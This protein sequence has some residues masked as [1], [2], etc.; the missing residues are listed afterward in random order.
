MIGI[1]Q[2]RVSPPVNGA[3]Q[4]F[5]KDTWR[6]EFKI[7]SEIGYDA[8]ELVFDDCENPLLDFEKAQE[9]KKLAD[10]SGIT[11]SSVSVDYTMHYPLFGETMMKS[12]RVVQ[13]LIRR[14]YDIGIHRIGIAFEDNSSITA[15]SQ[16]NQSIY[17]VQ[18]CVKI[19]EALN[20]IVT[21]ET[22]L[23][24]ANV[25]EFIRRIDSP[26]LKINFDLGNSCA[27]GEYP[28]DVIRSLG[29]LIGGIHIKDR[30]ML[31]GNTVP[32]GQ[33]DVDFKACFDAL[34]D[35]GYSGSLIIQG[36]RGSDDV[37]TAKVYLGF[38]RSYLR[39]RWV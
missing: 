39:Q 4:A 25:K 13:E 11:I 35:I 17:A 33:G 28:P 8:M 32:L 14:C 3:I 29:S 7:V 30:T 34:H 27:Y 21:I 2:G 12:I 10:T 15:T 19:A 24:V 1:V 36:A 20:I 23:L 9:I 6:D 26:N 16:R 37:H 5:P 22:S 31:F 38:V 18:E